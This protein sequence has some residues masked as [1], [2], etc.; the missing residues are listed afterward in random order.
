[1][2]MILQCVPKKLGFKAWLSKILW[3]SSLLE[4][5]LPSSK[6]ENQS[7]L[8]NQALLLVIVAVNPTFFGTPCIFLKISH[9]EEMPIYLLLPGKRCVTVTWKRV[10]SYI[11]LCVSSLLWYFWRLRN[12]KQRHPLWT[13]LQ[14][15][16][17]PFTI[18][19]KCE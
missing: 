2:P 12:C 14:V 16:S 6:D 8:L 13:K 18:I 3:F 7:I 4:G 1:M 19:I 9:Y 15:I 11:V 17:H 5:N 10:S